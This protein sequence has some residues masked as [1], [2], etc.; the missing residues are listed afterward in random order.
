MRLGRK[1]RI[2]C[3]FVAFS[4]LLLGLLCYSWYVRE[5]SRF[6]ANTS[7]SGLTFYVPS[8]L[9]AKKK[10]IE[11]LHEIISLLEESPTTENLSMDLVVFDKSDSNYSISKIGQFDLLA[12]AIDGVADISEFENVRDFTDKCYIG[13]ISVTQRG[14]P[15]VREDNKSITRIFKVAVGVVQSVPRYTEDMFETSGDGEYIL[16]D[17]KVQKAKEAGDLIYTQK[18]IETEEG[19]LTLISNKDSKESYGVLVGHSVDDNTYAKICET[20]SE[21]ISVR[22]IK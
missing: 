7:I 18:Y 14:E 4:S 2:L 5:N 9:E 22:K 16:N 13:D 21:K 19:Y 15:K 3:L 1:K 12:F 17:A 20:L 10:P 6:T 8:E 11:K